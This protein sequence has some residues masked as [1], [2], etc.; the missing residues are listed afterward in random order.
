MDSDHLRQWPFTGDEPGPRV[1]FEVY[2]R[3]VEAYRTCLAGLGYS[4][5]E[6]RLEPVA[7][8]YEWT[9]PEEADSDPRAQACYA[10]NLADL[11]L[12]WQSQRTRELA[13]LW[14]RRRRHIIECLAARG[15][16]VDGGLSYPEVVMAASR[17]G[18]SDCVVTAP[19]SQ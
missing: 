8:V 13:P 16:T 4:L 15:V 6:F 11:D 10:E 3:A 7:R 14:D 5:D 17:H 9:L 18:H 1:A 2:Q 19:W 12:R